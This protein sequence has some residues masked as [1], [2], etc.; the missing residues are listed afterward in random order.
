MAYEDLDA[1]LSRLEALLDRIALPEPATHQTAS[2]DLNP[3][4]LDRLASAIERID[5]I[6]AEVARREGTADWDPADRLAARLLLEHLTA[7]VRDCG[8]VAH[9]A[10]AHLE[11]VEGA[12]ADGRR[13]LD[14]GSTSAP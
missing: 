1:R 14:Q 12:L 8:V 11:R 10:A 6:A 13:L 4:V 9:A 2:G 3:A 5:R 7:A